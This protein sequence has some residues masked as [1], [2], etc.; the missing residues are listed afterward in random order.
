MSLYVH[1]WLIDRIN[2]IQCVFY[3][4]APKYWLTH[5]YTKAKVRIGNMNGKGL[6][7]AHICIFDAHCWHQIEVHVL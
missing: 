4:T 1:S 6:M 3:L 2:I 5:V 7:G